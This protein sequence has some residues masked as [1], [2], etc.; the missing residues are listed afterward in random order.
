M[1]SG[2]A[3]NLQE[4]RKFFDFTKQMALTLLSWK[5]CVYEIITKFYSFINNN[6]S[7]LIF[8][9]LFFLVSFF[10]LSLIPFHIILSYKIRSTILS[11]YREV[12]SY[13][14]TV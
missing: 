2:F 6:V 13:S 14:E 12:K 10:T 9:V 7:L 11:S 3:V 1:K 5:H 4:F 8:S